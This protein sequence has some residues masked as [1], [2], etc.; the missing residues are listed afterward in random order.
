MAITIGIVPCPEASGCPEL[1]A[2]GD[3]LYQGPYD[4]QPDGAGSN[5][6]DF[7]V[8]IPFNEDFI[9]PSQLT[10]NRFFLTG[11]SG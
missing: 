5:Y 2:V 9:G 10:V 4:P 7:T 3:V 8:T 6:Q 11:V 1:S